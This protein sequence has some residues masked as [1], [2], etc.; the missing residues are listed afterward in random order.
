MWWNGV[1][2][3]RACPNHGSL[4]DGDTSKHDNTGRQPDIIRQD[5]RRTLH[6]YGVYWVKVI[7]EHDSFIS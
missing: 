6:W 7:I 2:D 5:N 3:H 4:T 1:G